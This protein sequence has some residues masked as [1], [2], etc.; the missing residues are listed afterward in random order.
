MLKFR[1]LFR[2]TDGLWVKIYFI[3]SPGTLCFWFV[4]RYRSYACL[5]MPLSDWE[6]NRLC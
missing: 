5:G 1:G 3:V 6:Y 2:T 4:T